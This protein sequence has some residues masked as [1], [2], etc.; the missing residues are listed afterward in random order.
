MII[1]E[2]EID[3]FNSVASTLLFGW[4]FIFHALSEINLKARNNEL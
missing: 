3:V 4:I 2:P 1:I